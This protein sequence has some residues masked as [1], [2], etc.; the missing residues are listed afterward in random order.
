M[1]C[2]RYLTVLSNNP[3]G[4]N[5]STSTIVANDRHVSGVGEFSSK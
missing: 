5:W 4:F 2:Q 1:D 3:L